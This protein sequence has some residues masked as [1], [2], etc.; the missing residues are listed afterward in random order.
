M[1]GRWGAG[2]WRLP[3]LA[4]G[5][6]LAGLGLVLSSGP[7]DPADG[8]TGAAPSA[9]SASGATGGAGSTAAAPAPASAEVRGLR[10]ELV[11][12][13][14]ASGGEIAWWTTWR[15]C[16]DPVPGATAYLVTTVSF[17]GAGE[18][19]AVTETCHELGVASGTTRGSGSYPGRGAQLIQMEISMSVSVAA[20]MADGS[21]GPASPDIPVGAA[22]P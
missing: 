16:W 7:P 12:G 5:L 6:G 17:E 20:R 22:F 8:R 13:E 15:L 18:P 14:K 19:V 3:A 10:A 9:A 21:V 11:D 2:A 4:L 1:V